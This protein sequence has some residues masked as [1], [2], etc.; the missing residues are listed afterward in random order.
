MLH[1]G[2][3]LGP[4]QLVFPLITISRDEGSDWLRVNRHRGRCGGYLG[5]VLEVWGV[6]WG[7]ASTATDLYTPVSDHGGE[8]QVPAVIESSNGITFDTLCTEMYS[9]I[10]VQASVYK[11]VLS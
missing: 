11:I 5:G 9:L 1:N 2:L 6:C 3:T 10:K 7:C 4:P 8:G